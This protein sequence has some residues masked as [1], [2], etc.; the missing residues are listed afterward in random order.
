MK[1][2]LAILVSTGLASL[3]LA[4]CESTTQ[5][6]APGL[7]TQNPETGVKRIDPAPES[8]SFAHETKDVF[9]AAEYSQGPASLPN[10][11]RISLRLGQVVEVYRANIIPGG[12]REMAFYLPVEARA[13]VQVLIESRG[14]TK[15]YFLKAIG[16]GDT[17]GGVVERRWLNSGGFDANSV[18]DEARIQ[19]A[20]RAA[21]FLI[22]VTR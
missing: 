19:Q 1:N 13:V 2:R 10:A 7:D 6:V 8:K 14:V 12:E 15:T 11:K 3:L 4:A 5:G 16:P 9:R 20:V 18:A 17:V 22:S 21:P